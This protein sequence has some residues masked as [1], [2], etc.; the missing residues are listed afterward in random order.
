[1][2]N[3]SLIRQSDDF[4]FLNAKQMASLGLSMLD[5]VD[6]LEHMFRRKAGGE[7]QMPPKIF[8]HRSPIRFYSSMV[9]VAPYL[10]YAGCKW[11]SGNQDN[12]LSGLPSILGLFILVNDATG[13]PVAVMD[14]TWITAER[15]AA[16]SILVT[17]YQANANVKTLGMIGCGVQGRKQLEGILKEVP[18]II[19]CFAFDSELEVA[20]RYSREMSDKYK[21]DV[22]AVATPEKAVREADI[23]I[24]GG[25]I[26][27]DA[28]PVIKPDWIKAGCLGIS[29]DYDASWCPETVRNMDLVI[30]DDKIQLLDEQ[31]KGHFAGVEQIDAE[32]A[33]LVCHRKGIRT[34]TEQRI[35]TYNLG[36]ALED[37]VTAVELYKRAIRLDVG[38]RISM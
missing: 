20:K 25:V 28:T 8:E 27:K 31:S 9:S 22:I 10:G 38:T 7:T 18:T 21:I 26:R 16:A 30:T 23:V 33:D 1:M 15:T 35:L 2:T 3:K 11:Q 4:L 24:T 6:L 32:I 37:L 5:I 12:L 34:T 17:R 36:I 19:R 14:S 29:I 13:E